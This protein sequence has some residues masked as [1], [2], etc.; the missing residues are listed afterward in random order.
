[1]KY[2]IV[3][4]TILIVCVFVLN[5]STSINIPKPYVLANKDLPKL[6]NSGRMNDEKGFTSAISEKL[7]FVFDGFRGIITNYLKAEKL[8]SIRK[9]EG[10]EALTFG[11]FKFLEQSKED[12]G[13][14]FR[15]AIT[16]PFSPEFFFYSYLVMPIMSFPSNPWAWSAM[17]SSFDNEET[18]QK[19]QKIINKRR[20]QALVRSLVTLKDDTLDNIA[21]K[22]RDIREGQLAV[23]CKSL[24]RNKVSIAAAMDEVKDWIEYESKSPKSFEKLSIRADTVPGAVIKDCCRA[25]G[26]E[27]VPNIPLIRRFNIAELSK[28]I[29]KIK[30]SDDFIRKIGTKSLSEEELQKACDERCISTHSKSKK[31]LCSDIDQWLSIIYKPSNQQVIKDGNSKLY[32][33]ANPYNKRFALMTLYVAKEL[34]SSDFG[35]MYNDLFSK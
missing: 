1:M 17:P 26:A 28:Y 6:A 14:I 27:G 20:I 15:L 18:Y 25:I 9:I 30:N 4:N 10:E 13:K 3:L 11:E 22:T 35:S 2:R 32:F 33:A 31:A 24:K 5:P 29:E 34:K 12:I 23:I 8:K 21:E 19:R 16:I 7:F